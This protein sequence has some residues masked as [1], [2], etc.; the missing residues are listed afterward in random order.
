MAPLGSVPKGWLQNVK[1][2]PLVEFELA[3]P[4]RSQDFR[5]SINSTL[6]HSEPNPTNILVSPVSIDAIEV[7]P[8]LVKTFFKENNTL[9]SAV[10]FRDR[11]ECDHQVLG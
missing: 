4:I 6:P 10:Y 7:H 9:N 3:Q 11:R 8:A 2:R 1:L 5:A